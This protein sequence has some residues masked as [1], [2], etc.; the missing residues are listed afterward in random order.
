MRVC[1]TPALGGL[2]LT[3]RACRHVWYQYYSCGHS[4]CP[5][6]QGNKR[7]AWHDR[8]A[9]RLLEV[10]Y[11]HV[12]FTLPHELNGLCRL[13]PRALYGMLFRVVRQTLFELCADAEHVGG[14]P[15]ITAVLH[16]WG[17]DLK[18][19]VHLHCLVTYGGLDE[20]NGTWRWP[21]CRYALIRYR[22][23]RGAFRA[24]FLRALEEWMKDPAH[25][26]PVYR[27]SY[28][29]L[30]ADLKNKAWVVNQ[31]RPTAR[32]EVINAY[33]S[34]YICRIGISDKRL[35]YDAKNQTVRLEYKDYRCQQPGHP[36][37][38][39][40]RE[41]DPLLAMRMILQH[42]LP[43]NFHRTRQY[44]LH[45][46]ATRKR[47]RAGLQNWVRQS[48][49]WVT[50]LIRILKVMLRQPLR[51]CEQCGVVAEVHRERVRPDRRF[52]RTFLRLARC[53]P[54]DLDGWQKVSKAG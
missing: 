48:V 17:S 36:A 12:T 51:G 53:P 43:A 47:L 54:S 41:L 10:P 18:H 49:D 27:Q 39:A 15:G 32:P 21:K 46:A 28:E 45:H 35:V 40:Y 2:R 23:I 7:R 25:E 22:K 6:C 3:C 14:L 52:K 44:G 37:P 13:H 16:T 1:R 50:V 9:D 30:T 29:E 34:R 33:L 19:H 4:H 20:K 31:Q 5:L 42:L 38:V 8:V 24:N 26:Q 11:V